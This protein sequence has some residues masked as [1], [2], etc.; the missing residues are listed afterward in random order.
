MLMILVDDEVIY[1]ENPR[2]KK[3]SKFDDQLSHMLTSVVIIDR[4]DLFASLPPRFQ[5]QVIS[6]KVKQPYFR[7]SFFDFSNKQKSSLLMLSG[8]VS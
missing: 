7:V 2:R 3:T 4:N 5:R 8:G 1:P 6:K